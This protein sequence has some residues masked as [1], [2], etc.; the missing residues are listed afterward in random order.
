MV[1]L[2]VI[3]GP[4]QGR[5]YEL[6]DGQYHIGRD[7]GCQI[8]LADAA[9]SRLHALLTVSGAGA[10][11]QDLGSRHGTQ[12]T[13]RPVQA[14]AVSPAD[15]V[16]VGATV[17][18]IGPASD[19]AGTTPQSGWTAPSR[20]PGVNWRRNLTIFAVVLILLVLSSCCMLWPF[21]RG[22]TRGGG[23]GRSM[24]G[25]LVN[26]RDF[27]RIERG[28]SQDEV[29]RICGQ[30]ML[31][32]PE[33]YAGGV[34]DSPEVWHYGNAEIDFRDEKVV[35]KRRTTPGRGD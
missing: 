23:L 8:Q 26:D 12:V 3:S 7:P 16:Q 2:T 15:T 27:A 13:G 29:L 25:W 17:F 22:F 19:T 20:A 35:A 32:E 4:D 31:R 24:G 1:W 18:T 10:Q 34:E 6:I 21:L 14:A 33:G 11:I 5:V 30:P 9:V 28:M